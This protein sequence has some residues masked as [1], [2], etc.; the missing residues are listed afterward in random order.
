LLPQISRNVAAAFDGFKVG[1]RKHLLAD[2]KRLLAGI[3]A[4]N[5]GD[6]PV[7]GKAT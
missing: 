5:A 6:L 7:R 1:E 4:L 2:L 3:D